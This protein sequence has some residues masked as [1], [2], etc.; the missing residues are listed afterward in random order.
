MFG[1]TRLTD[2]CQPQTSP[3]FEGRCDYTHVSGMED[4]SPTPPLLRPGNS[5]L[6]VRNQELTSPPNLL[7]PSSAIDGRAFKREDSHHF[8]VDL[9]HALNN[10]ASYPQTVKENPHHQYIDIRDVHP[11]YYEN[12]SQYFQYPTY[13]QFPSYMNYQTHPFGPPTPAPTSVPESPAMSQYT[14][15]YAWPAQDDSRSPFK[16]RRDD[17]YY[18]MNPEEDDDDDAALCDKPY[19]RLIYEALMQAPSHRMML[20]EIYDWFQRNTTKPAESGTNGWQNSIR[21]NLSMNQVS[22]GLQV[23]LYHLLTLPGLRK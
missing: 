13:Q 16:G 23:S 3:Y 7:P 5:V 2:D 10:V 11:S 12:S 15:T 22:S 20:R 4:Q 19:A 9:Q 6:T 17:N 8:A 14:C 1:S 21:H 18:A